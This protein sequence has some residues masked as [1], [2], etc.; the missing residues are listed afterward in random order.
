MRELYIPSVVQNIPLFHPTF[1]THIVELFVCGL[2]SWKI[3]IVNKFYFILLT[4]CMN[5]GIFIVTHLQYLHYDTYRLLITN[6][7]KTPDCL[8]DNGRPGRD[9]NGLHFPIIDPIHDQ[10]IINILDYVFEKWMPW[11]RHHCTCFE[12]PLIHFLPYYH[13]IFIKGV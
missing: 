8:R 10:A 9:M 5:R 7:Q 3:F 11:D 12:M 2:N 4:N 13:L 6:P 1:R